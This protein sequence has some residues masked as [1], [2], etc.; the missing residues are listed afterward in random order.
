MSIWQIWPIGETVVIL[1]IFGFVL[2]RMWRTMKARAKNPPPQPATRAGR[3]KAGSLYVLRLVGLLVGSLL[4]L[5]LFI[6]VER[7]MLLVIMDTAPVRSAVTVPANLGFDVEE[8]AFEGDDGLRMSGWYIPPQ[9]GAVVIL[10]HGYGGNRTSMIW[11]AGQLVHAGYGVLMYDE[12]A[13]G[14]SE[15]AYRSYGWEDPRDVAGAIRFIEARPDKGRGRI[16][17]AGCSTGADVSVVS[18]ALYPELEAVW[19]DGSSMVR[20]KDLPAPNRL[21][22]ALM[23]PGQRIYEWMLAIKLGITPPAPLVDVVD[24][25]APRPIMFVGGGMERPLVGSE[26]D[27]FT[28]R[29]AE[30]AGP[31]AQA[32]VI[33]E[34][35][36]CDGPRVRPEEYAA[37]MVAFFDE[38]FGIER[39]E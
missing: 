28:L 32:W 4:A 21:M 7:N 8:V 27:A 17:I 19:S 34:A 14:E 24:G 22:I 5:T 39:D 1:A 23:Y 37:K 36:H 33:P 15:G 20:A 6:M 3:F 25:I 31:N 26:A 11:H 16:G 29:Y 9:N 35:T 10:L 12:R 13:S 38:A 2:F 30:L 18:A